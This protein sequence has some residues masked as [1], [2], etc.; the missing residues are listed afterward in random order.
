MLNFLGVDFKYFFIT[1]CS[2]FIFKKLNSI[3][4]YYKQIAV[5]IVFSMITAT[6]VFFTRE[7]LSVLSLFFIVSFTTALLKILYK[8]SFDKTLAYTIISVAISF[9]AY[10]FATLTIGTITFPLSS[11]VNNRSLLALTTDL[12][13]GLFQ[14]LTCNLL[15]RIKR[16]KKGIAAYESKL[17]S[18]SG[19]FISLSLLL[20]A[21]LLGTD[22]NYTVTQIILICLF[23]IGMLLFFWWRNHIKNIYLEKVYKRNIEILEN[24][25][26]E[27]KTENEML[28]KQNDELSKIIHKDNKVIPAMNMAVEEILMCQSAD[29]QINKARSLH[30]Q[31]KAMTSERK[32]IVTEYESK[33]KTLASTG[34]FSVDASLNYLLARAKEKEVLFDLSVTDGI[35]GC[36][37]KCVSENDLNTLILDLGENAIIAASFSEKK[38]VFVMIGTD[39]K[40]LCLYIYDSGEYFD[41]DVI[42]NLGKKRITTHRKSGGSGIGMMTTFSL[43]QKYGAS[44]KIDETVQNDS[45][46]KCVSAIFDNEGK[47]IIKS[48]GKEIADISEKRKEFIFE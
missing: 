11:L 33:S 5:E 42:A 25:V 29:E 41:T 12:S 21:S 23:P 38:N 36:I 14:L 32:G 26:S 46:T 35:K 1:L 6:A 20:I 22:N 45:Y 39:N 34:V 2:V 24:T 10:F 19:V 37:D 31:L 7:A 17:T 8:R 15:F 18:D 30:S 9:I 44:L 28:I 40:K 48:K 3:K 43:L 4:S 16:L 13:V 27:Q 47:I